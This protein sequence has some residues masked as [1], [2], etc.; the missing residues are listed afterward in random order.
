M[1]PVHPKGIC[2]Y[3]LINISY[4]LADWRYAKALVCYSVMLHWKNGEHKE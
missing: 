4:Y 2:A 1:A 3:K